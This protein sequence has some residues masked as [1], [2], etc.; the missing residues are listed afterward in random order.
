MLTSPSEIRNREFSY[1]T[2]CKSIVS[3]GSVVY[4]LVDRATTSGRQ[5]NLGHSMSTWQTEVILEPP[6]KKTQLPARKEQRV[7]IFVERSR[8]GK[9]GKN[10]SRFIR[11]LLFDGHLHCPTE[12]NFIFFNGK[13]NLPGWF[14]MT[15]PF[16][17]LGFKS[18]I[19]MEGRNPVLLLLT[20]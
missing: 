18:S 9:E 13:S 6:L 1:T 17:L 20:K 16:S 19:R 4:G 3:A 15:C 14:S 11:K 12:C 5:H 2:I 10:L 7:A 8:F